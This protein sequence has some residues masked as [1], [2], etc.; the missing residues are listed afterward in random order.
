M[1]V[2]NLE[3]ILHHA[4]EMG[5]EQVSSNVER[6][7]SNELS[8]RGWFSIFDLRSIHYNTLDSIR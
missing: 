1:F 7:S 8:V 4:F 2:N 3:W 6:Y 5:F